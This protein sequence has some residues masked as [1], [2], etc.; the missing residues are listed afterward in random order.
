MGRRLRALRQLDDRALNS[1]WGALIAPW[2]W[3]AYRSGATTG[4]RGNRALGYVLFSWPYGAIFNRGRREGTSI[5]KAV[6]GWTAALIIT[7]G[8][9]LVFMFW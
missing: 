4:S 1:W 5:P 8:P 2:A 3:I 9:L 7:V 6:L